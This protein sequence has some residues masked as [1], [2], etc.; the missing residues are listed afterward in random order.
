[1][2]D[3]STPDA[4]YVP[5]AAPLVDLVTVRA[6]NPGPMTLQG[7]NTYLIRDADQV[8][9]VDPGPRDPEHL[10][11][12]L[13]ACGPAARPQGVLLTHHHA[14]HAAGAATLARQLAARSGTEV[15]LWSADPS[16]VPGSRPVPAELEGDGG[17][18]AHVI[19]LPGHTADSLG[20]LV[21][22]GRM[23]TGDTILGGSST[24]VVPEHGGDLRA[25]L[26]SLAILRVMVLDGRIS[27]LHPAHGDPYTDPIAALATIEEAMEHRKER[28]EQVRRARMAGILTMDRLLRTVY[29]PDLPEE[30]RKAAEWNLR[31]ALDYISAG[32]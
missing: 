25:F 2:N 29:G 22:G 16:L 18:V 11:E 3:D 5:P 1:M 7:T 28:I 17:V 32:H 21:E 26:Q 31:A 19:H 23:L 9:V 6:P 24:V 8:W 12:I 20:L 14:D 10:A 4:P 30:K 27:S 13:H 15:P